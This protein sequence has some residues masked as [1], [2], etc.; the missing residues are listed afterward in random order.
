M[1]CASRI[2]GQNQCS[3]QRRPRIKYC[4]L[5]A[6][7][8]SVLPLPE[9]VHDDMTLYGVLENG[10]GGPEAVGVRENDEVEVGPLGRPDFPTSPCMDTQRRLLRALRKKGKMA[11]PKMPSKAWKNYSHLSDNWSDSP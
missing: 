10:A 2:L 8:V 5:S 3:A 9:H 7:R 1:L 6:R 11:S 4:P